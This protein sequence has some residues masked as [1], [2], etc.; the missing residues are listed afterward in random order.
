MM[1]K[2]LRSLRQRTVSWIMNQGPSNR[3]ASCV[4]QLACRAKGAKLSAQ[5]AYLSLRNG[6][7]E[8]RL[9]RHHF[10][11][12]VDMAARF[13]I[14]YSVVE[15]HDEDGY[16]VV[17]YSTPRLQRYCQS[18]MEFE[19][20]SFPEEQDSIDD[21]FRWYTP[22]PGDI[23]FDVGAHC[24]VSSFEF[25]RRVGPSG[26][27]F[28]M[29]PDPINFALLQRNIQRHNL[30]NV[31]ALQIALSDSNGKALFNSEGT[32]GSGLV[33]VFDRPTTGKSIEV[34]TA[35]LEELCHRYGRPAF[36][37]ID[38]EGAEIEVLRQAAGFLH[39]T[40][41][42]LVLDTHHFVR[43]QQTTAE[44]ENLLRQ[45]GYRV[46]SSAESGTTTTWAE[47]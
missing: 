3:L 42:H 35:T 20:A 43:G 28:A 21:Y 13:D 2:G 47:Q 36:C 12:C 38:I 9:A 10:A 34:E 39:Q 17:D 15:P 18:G 16:K 23:V 41:M 26:R 32:I 6:D 29:E 44:T 24:G 37:K 30:T 31:T 25:S 11:Y 1:P 22:S 46:M 5:P 14:Y 40:P 27:V 7:R 4:L 8:M 45:A 33:F 19:L